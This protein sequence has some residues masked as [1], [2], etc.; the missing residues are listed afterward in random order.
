M[1]KDISKKGSKKLWSRSLLAAMTVTTAG[2]GMTGLASASS[3]SNTGPGSYNV[4][5]SGGYGSDWK[6]H[7]SHRDGYKFVWPDK[8]GKDDNKKKYSYDWWKNDHKDDKRDDKKDGH[9]YKKY[10]HKD[11]KHGGYGGHKLVW[12]DKHD[13]HDD[14]DKHSYVWKNDYN[15]DHKDNWWYGRNDHKDDKKYGHNDDKHGGYGGHK[16]DHKYGYD[17]DKDDRW[18]EHDSK[19]AH[20]D[21]YGGS[22]RLSY[23]NDVDYSVENN[24]DVNIDNDVDQV[25]VS[26]D[27]TSTRNT[28]GGHVT[29]G[30]A[31]NVSENTFEVDV[32]NTSAADGLGGS[33]SGGFDWNKLHDTGPYSHNRFDFSNRE[34]YSVENNTD[35]DID[36]NVSQTAVTGDATSSRNTHGGS[37]RSGDASNYSSNTFMVKVEN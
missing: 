17:N 9:N 18:K 21:G 33:G 24:T 13:K 28:W 16:D 22:T 29:T 1:A 27:A 14:K 12:S 37:V 3:I 4:I 25:A 5:S 34:S 23:S 32:D 6:G 10:G 7:D 36:N 15:K 8:Y 11:D 20:H 30:D 26:G 35:V 19:Y 31:T 2:A